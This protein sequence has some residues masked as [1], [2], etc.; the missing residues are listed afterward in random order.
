MCRSIGRVN[1]IRNA[2]KATVDAYDGTTKLYVFAPD[3]P[4]IRAYQHLFPDLFQPASEMPADLRAHARYPED[5]VP[6]AGRDLPHLPHARPAGLLQQGGRVGHR[7][8]TRSQANA[9]RSP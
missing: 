6:R 5:P 1:Y 8:C 4:I 3:D 9:G 2:V 7:A